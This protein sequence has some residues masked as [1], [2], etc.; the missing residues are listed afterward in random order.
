MIIAGL[1]KYYTSK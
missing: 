1:K